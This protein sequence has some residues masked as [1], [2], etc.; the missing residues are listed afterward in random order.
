MKGFSLRFG[1]YHNSKH[2]ALKDFVLELFLYLYFL[3]VFLLP[4]LR[5]CSVQFIHFSRFNKTIVHANEAIKK[6]QQKYASRVTCF[7]ES[8]FV[9]V[10]CT[11]MHLPLAK[12][13]FVSLVPF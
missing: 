3:V 2:M 12:A 1:L 9:I 6:I 5:I 4:Y 11:F 10:L 8:Y 7:D 13:T